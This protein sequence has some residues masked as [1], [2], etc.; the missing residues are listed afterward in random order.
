MLECITHGGM[1]KKYRVSPANI[2]REDLIICGDI[3]MRK[4]LTEL[5]GFAYAKA[6]KMPLTKA[7]KTPTKVQKPVAYSPTRVAQQPVLNLNYGT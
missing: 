6:K 5:A 2:S 1:A 3:C 7:Q 4:G